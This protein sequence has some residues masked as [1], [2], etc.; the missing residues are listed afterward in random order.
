V[1]AVPSKSNS[2]CVSPIKSG[3]FS[4]MP[5]RKR[6]RVRELQ[7]LMTEVGWITLP[8]VTKAFR[9]LADELH[10]GQQ[11]LNARRAATN[12]FM[13]VLSTDVKLV[14]D[15]IGAH[16]ADFRALQRRAFGARSRRNQ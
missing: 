9:G 4:E 15:T 7:S 6:P 2:P 12:G 11:W 1:R 5:R 13:R 3:R 10:D 8:A 14:G 16:L